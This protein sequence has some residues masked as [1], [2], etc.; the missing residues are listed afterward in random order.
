MRDSLK[1]AGLIQAL[2]QQLEGSPGVA[3]GAL[4]PFACATAFLTRELGLGVEHISVPGSSPGQDQSIL[5][6]WGSDR[7]IGEH[8]SR[9]HRRLSFGPD[10][11]SGIVRFKLSLFPDSEG[12]AVLPRTLEAHPCRAGRFHQRP[13]GVQSACLPHGRTGGPRDRALRVRFRPRGGTVRP[14]LH[15]SLEQSVGCQGINGIR[16]PGFVRPF[17]TNASWNSSPE[18]PRPIR[19]SPGSSPGIDT[20]LQQSPASLF[21]RRG[22]C[23]KRS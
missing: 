10:T 5:P 19:R 7:R 13:G 1:N 2:A 22:S 18:S 16:L 15:P 11:V 8:Q 6:G 4:S 20:S 3:V 9:R 14:L 17:P 12:G 21:C 23:G